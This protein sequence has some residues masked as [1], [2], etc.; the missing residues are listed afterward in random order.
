MTLANFQFYYDNINV[1]TCM[2]AR[3][4]S[5]SESVKQNHYVL[6]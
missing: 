4:T 2:K 6:M 3:I 1:N 5:N